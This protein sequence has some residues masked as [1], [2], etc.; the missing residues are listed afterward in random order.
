MTPITEAPIL[1]LLRWSVHSSHMCT[2]SGVWLDNWIHCSRRDTY[3]IQLHVIDQMSIFPDDSEYYTCTY[4]PK[5]IHSMTNCSTTSLHLP[6]HV[7]PLRLGIHIVR[8]YV[9]FG[10][11][12]LRL[13]LSTILQLLNRA[14]VQGEN[15]T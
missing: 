2:Q 13:K 4:P 3:G 1:V 15:V 8:L 10:V 11:R 12:P 14:G 5:L 6:L 7:R 9:P